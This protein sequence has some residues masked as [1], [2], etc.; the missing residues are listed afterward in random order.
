MQTSMTVSQ[1]ITKQISLWGVKQI[2]GVAG[3]AL[4]PWLDELGK[5]Q[6]IQFIATRHESAAAMMAS[7]EAKLT[8]KPAVCMATSGPGI[9]NLLNGLADAHMD[10]V[11]VVAI[12]GQVDTKR[13]GSHYK[14]YLQQ[15]EIVAPISHYSAEV[16][17]PDQIAEVLQRAFI[18]AQQR[19]GVA[20]VSI[21]KDVLAK[22]TS[23]PLSAQLPRV[24]HHIQ[25]DRSEVTG[26]LE[27]MK[28]VRRPLLLLGTG[29]REAQSWLI[30]FAERLG[31]GILLSLGAKG[32]V[33]DHHPFVLG[34][35]G[36]GGSKAAIQALTEADSL[37]ILGATWFPKSYIPDHLSLI[38]IDE[39][40]ESIHPAANMQSVIANLQDVLPTWLRKLQTSHPEPNVNWQL[41]IKQL[42]EEYHRE[43]EIHSDAAAEEGIRPEHLIRMIQE[44]VDSDAIITVDTGEHTI[45]FNRMFRAVNQLPLFSGK[46]RTMG[47]G[48]PAGIA[49]KIV[50]PNRQVVVLVGDGGIQMNLAE[51]MTLKQYGQGVTV[52][53]VNNRSLGLEIVK[54]KA[55]G[56]APFGLQLDNPDFSL[57]A[58]ACGLNS[59][60]VEKVDQ[61]QEQLTRALKSGEATILDVSCTYPT[62]EPRKK[63]FVLQMK[64]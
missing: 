4:F 8:H 28:Q 27:A 64:A 44:S 41:R 62:L 52:V 56:F 53:V 47:Y 3:D 42:H 55:E 18:T 10:R 32:C 51:L 60:K 9:V 57:I 31:A 29:A 54:M 24:T 21:C 39:N 17:N 12:T 20:H 63:D 13:I 23:L 40:P 34:G 58:K 2:Y 15:Q 49:A 26:A 7:A 37:I 16:V 46:W 36:E 43:T 1:Y 14:Q 59:Y 30:P 48:L 45:W 35:V 61:L 5:Q 25:P 19:K 22:T 33:P 11:P 50:Q 38:Q 6:D